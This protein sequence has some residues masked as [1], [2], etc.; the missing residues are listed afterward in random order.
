MSA[1]GTSGAGDTAKHDEI[2]SL[3]KKTATTTTTTATKQGEAA[4]CD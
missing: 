3:K 1:E 2:R 4:D